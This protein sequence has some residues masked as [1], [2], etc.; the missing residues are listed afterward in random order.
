MEDED[1]KLFEEALAEMS[2]EDVFR[3]KFGGGEPRRSV[4]Q[5]EEPVDEQLD[6]DAREQ[7]AMLRDEQ[8]MAQAFAGV[9]KINSAKYHVPPPRQAAED[10]DPAS[11][12]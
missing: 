3:G 4:A 6:A 5:H 8:M 1:L 12:K 7:V 2:A 9:R 10:A 11:K